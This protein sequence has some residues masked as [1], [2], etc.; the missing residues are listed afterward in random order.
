MLTES[1]KKAMHLVLRQ[2]RSSQME[3]ELAILSTS[4][5]QVRNELTDINI[6]LMDSITKLTKV[7]R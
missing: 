2:L 6:Y 5:G 1:T 7:L 3:V 4:S